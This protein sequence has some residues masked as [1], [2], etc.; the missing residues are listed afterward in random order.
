VA[1]LSGQVAAQRAKMAGGP[2]TMAAALGPYQNLQLRRDFAAKRYEAAAAAV[3]S[4]RQEALRQQLY[5]VRVVEPNR[6]EKALYPRR[7]L[8]LASVFFTALLIYGVGWLI[9][10]GV[11]EHAA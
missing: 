5:V 6:P 11:R 8:M 9:V 10:A 4:A 1:G 7:W 2:G 3:E